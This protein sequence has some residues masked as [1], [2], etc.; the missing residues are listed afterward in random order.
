MDVTSNAGTRHTGRIRTGLKA[1]ASLL[2]LILFGVAL[3]LIT[4]AG[5][6]SAAGPCGPPVVSVIACENTAS[7]DPQSDWLGAGAGDQTLQGYP[8]PTSAHVGPTVS[9]QIRPTQAP[10]P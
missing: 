9:F 1:G 4:N 7:G 3:P 6:A 10:H 2:A 8:P 5:G